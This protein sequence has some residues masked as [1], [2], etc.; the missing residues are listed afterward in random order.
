MLDSN[1]IECK[2][3]N[4]SALVSPKIYSNNNKYYAAYAERWINKLGKEKGRIIIKIFN[5]LSDIESCKPK[6]IFYT[7]ESEYIDMGYPTLT[8]KENYINIIWYE[9][10]GLSSSYIFSSSIKE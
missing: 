3:L 7:R 2:N 1:I 6:K 9:K 4:K 8:F 5:N 10:V